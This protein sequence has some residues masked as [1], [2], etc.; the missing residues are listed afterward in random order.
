AEF[1]ANWK[2]TLIASKKKGLEHHD[3]EIECDPIKLST[4]GYFMDQMALMR[5]KDASRGR[6]NRIH[7][8]SFSASMVSSHLVYDKSV[9]VTDHVL[10]IVDAILTRIADDEFKASMIKRHRQ[11]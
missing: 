8:M 4:T 5:K 9:K 6:E 10:L 2:V 3:L 1:E 11:D 7:P